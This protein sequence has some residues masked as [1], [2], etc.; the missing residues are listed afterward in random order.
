M[1]ARNN[2]GTVTIRDVTSTAVS[3]EQL[4]IHA[5]KE[6]LFSVLSVP[7]D[8]KKDKE[9]FIASGECYNCLCIMVTEI[10]KL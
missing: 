10:L 3:K 5:T 9:D 2:G 8:Y 4:R 1:L 7:T 6:E